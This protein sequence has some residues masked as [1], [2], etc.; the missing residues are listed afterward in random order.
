MLN[1]KN[2]SGR[3]ETPSKAKPALVVSQFWQ[4]ANKV[5]TGDVIVSRPKRRFVAFGR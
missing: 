4:F 3:S 5:T 2:A 1:L